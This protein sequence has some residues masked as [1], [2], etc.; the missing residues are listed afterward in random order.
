MKKYRILY[1]ICLL[2]IISCAKDIIDLSGSIEGIVKDNVTSEPLQGVSITL[3]PSGKSATTGNDG[4]YSFTE[5]DAGNYSIEF[6]KVGYEANKKEVTVLAGKPMQVDA[7]LN[8]ITNAL[9]VNPTTLNFG[10]L[11][12]SK[13]LFVYSLEQLGD[14]R[15]TIKVDAD[16]ISLSKS[17][18]NATS[19]GDKITITI[20]RSKLSIG[21]YEK[22][23]TVTS[24]YGEVVIPVIVN[25]VERDIATL[26]TNAPEN[27]TETSLTI[28]GTIVK[29]G[30]LKITSHGHCWS[31]TEQPTIDNSKNNLGD[32]ESIGDFTST[33]TNLVAGKSYFIRAYAINSKG[34][35]YSEQVSVTMPFI[36][37]PTVSTLAISSLT[38][39]SVILNGEVKDNGNGNIKEYGFYWGL[40]DN[41]EHKVKIS[42]IDETKFSYTLKSLES[43]ATYYYK[44][45]AINEKG[46]STG[47]IKT[48]TSL[49]K[50]AIEGVATVITNDATDITINSATLNGV[51]TDS[52]DTK[53]IQRGFYFGTSE[54]SMTKKTVNTTDSIISLHVTDLAD[55]TTYYYKAFAVNSKGE[56]CGSTNSFTTLE[57]M[58]PVVVTNEATDV[59]YEQAVLNGTIITLGDYEI[60]EC[61]FYYGTDENSMTKIV[62]SRND[63]IISV[64]TDNLSTN[65]VYYYKT[66]VA[67]KKGEVYGDILAFSTLDENVVLPWDGTVASSFAGGSGTYIDPYLIKTPNQLAYISVAGTSFAYYKVMYNLDLN[68][69]SWKP[70]NNFNGNFDG[71][72][73]TISNLYIN[74]SQDNIGLFRSGH[75]SISNLTIEN[76][77]IK[78]T[79]NN[80]TGVLFGTF[81]GEIDNCHIK[82]GNGSIVGNENVGGMIGYADLHDIKIT[83]CTTTSK[84]T[85][86]SI[87]GNT[88]VGGIVGLLYGYEYGS[89]E[90][91]EPL[92]NCKVNLYIKGENKIG[93]LIGCLDEVRC[94]SLSI[95]NCSYDGTIYGVNNIGGI[96]GSGYEHDYPGI[97]K[98]YLTSVRSIT[99][100][101]ATEGYTGGLIGS[102]RNLDVYILSSYSD[103]D[104]IKSSKFCGGLIGHV[105][106]RNSEFHSSY[107]VVQFNENVDKGVSGGFLGYLDD[108][109]LIMTHSYTN[110]TSSGG[111]SP[112]GDL[113]VKD[114]YQNCSNNEI[115]TYM[116]NS[117]SEYLSNWNFNNTYTWNG[118]ID[119][120]SKSV[121]CP[122]LSWE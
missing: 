84:S 112:H 74:G 47:E 37:K 5:L 44:A 121:V 29:T 100:I 26:T 2:L 76:I 106:C 110:Y 115:I 38:K 80:N 99:S 88:A 62:G 118:T 93:G 69:K 52:G 24:S 75:G 55:G 107:S 32:T 113:R 105:F 114:S 35:A 4:R 41:T 96:I 119:G 109:K 101:S 120:V 6:S 22:N 46:E 17:D 59:S 77:N 103:V 117:Y 16:W 61:G 85:N 25:Q 104:F 49:D 7:M 21:N 57:G 102:C 60:L 70:I 56:S 90:K 82:I 86:A 42:T 1:I 30:G 8:K 58:M 71:N 18:G 108:G 64:T 11:E 40:T 72:G 15:Y 50:D 89:D 33:L 97:S 53:V 68:N 36:E 43:K 48:F 54:S 67:T 34:V 95:A 20:D 13:T 65:T 81:S 39:D 66:Y 63:N 19:T 79:S 122:R 51:I 94:Y 78:N 83:N 92:T 73:K 98:L 9:I 31:E 111:S 28:K 12:T 45:Y 3:S 10:D 14:I 91:L 116:Q 23:I 87:L 27:I